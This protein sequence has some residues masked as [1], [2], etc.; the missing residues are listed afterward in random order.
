MNAPLDQSTFFKKKKHK[1]FV[2]RRVFLVR[3]GM[4]GK[5]PHIEVL[6]GNG[7]DQVSMLS[8]SS[9]IHSAI[10]KLQYAFNSQSACSF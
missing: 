3:Q 4:L 2:A 8:K 9:H 5:L 10:Y 6:D 7:H 1:Q